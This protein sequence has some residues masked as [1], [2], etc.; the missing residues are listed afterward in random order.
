[1]GDLALRAKVRLAV[2]AACQRRTK[3]SISV[4]EKI[5]AARCE[6]QERRWALHNIEARIVL[7]AQEAC[8][9]RGGTAALA[10]AAMARPSTRKPRV[11]IPEGKLDEY[12]GRIYAQ[13]KERAKNK[14]PC[15]TPASLLHTS[16]DDT[17]LTAYFRKVLNDVK[18]R[19][20][21]TWVS[22]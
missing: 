13:A 16:L 21:K 7:A 15:A 18:A 12:V 8:M 14:S 3:E 6:A 11:E 22:T 9:K 10:R 5:E 17:Q 1:M 4:E 19:S 2:Q 20:G